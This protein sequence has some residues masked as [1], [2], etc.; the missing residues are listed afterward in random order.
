MGSFFNY[1]G[2]VLSALNKMCDIIFLGLLWI[3][4]CIPIVTI[5]AST[6]A[7]YYTT[8]K[9]IRKEN[10]YVF[11]QFWNAF[12][13]NFFNGTVYTVIL[14]LLSTIFIMNFTYVSQVEKTSST[15]LFYIYVIMVYAIV[16]TVIY[17][18]PALSRF[19]MK[20]FDLVKLSF[21]MATRHLP[22]TI[23]MQLILLGGAFLLYL[24]PP[25][26]LIIPPLASLLISFVIEK[27]FKKYMPESKEDDPE[28]KEW[29]E[30]F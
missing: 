18:F 16:A 26:I 28:R 20:R 21:F 17:L 1:E 30:D 2:G 12:K 5:G 25:A 9:V 23:L 19:E 3:V 24:I 7:L 6:T 15:V 27:V 13:S 29:Y 10:G 14:L 11:K 4:F 22:S 8:A